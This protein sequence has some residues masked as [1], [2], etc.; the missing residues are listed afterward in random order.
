LS[1]DNR[2]LTDDEVR[3]IKLGDL[4]L[5]GEHWRRIDALSFSE[6]V[7]GWPIANIHATAIDAP[8]LSVSLSISRAV[9]ARRIRFN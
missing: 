1:K 2:G 6:S 3:S 7:C 4:V 9:P 8:M 5:S